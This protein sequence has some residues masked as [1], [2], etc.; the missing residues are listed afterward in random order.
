MEYSR[1]LLAWWWR[2]SGNVATDFHVFDVKLYAMTSSLAESHLYLGAPPMTTNISETFWFLGI[3]REDCSISKGKIILQNV[4]LKWITEFL[5]YS[6][7]SI[8]YFPCMV[9]LRV[10]FG[11]TT[12]CKH[13]HTNTHA[14][15]RTQL[16]DVTW[17][18]ILITCIYLSWYCRNEMT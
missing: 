2:G 6:V 18:N 17:E 15:A 5:T 7:Q 14:S 3:V 11:F 16:S 12:I 13:T 8:W 9:W 1:N 4:N 10:P